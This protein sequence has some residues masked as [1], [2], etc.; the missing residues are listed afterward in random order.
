MPI[1]GFS[2]K[3]LEVKL[4]AGEQKAAEILLCLVLECLNRQSWVALGQVSKWLTTLVITQTRYNSDRV[5]CT[6]VGSLCKW[7]V[8]PRLATTYKVGR[9]TQVLL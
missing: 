1:N 3:P 6:Y 4:F 5:S 7:V 2:I 9:Y 8:P